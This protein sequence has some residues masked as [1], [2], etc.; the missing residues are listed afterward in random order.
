MQMLLQMCCGRSSY[1][2]GHNTFAD[3]QLIAAA[4]ISMQGCVR[5]EPWHCSFSYRF[6][7][8]CI[9]SAAQ[10]NLHMATSLLPQKQPRMPRSTR[11][12]SSWCYSN[13][14]CRYCC[15]C[16]CVRCSSATRRGGKPL[17][18]L[19]LLAVATEE[20]QHHHRI[21]AGNP[22][23]EVLERLYPWYVLYRHPSSNTSTSTQSSGYCC[24]TCYWCCYFCCAAAA[25]A[26]QCCLLHGCI[27]GDIAHF[28]LIWSNGVLLLLLRYICI[29]LCEPIL[30]TE[31]TAAGSF[32]VAWNLL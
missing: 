27:W 21:I 13:E 23:L 4:A 9:C 18:L 8:Y 5:T 28:L 1:C 11:S 29:E 12:S 25:A 32:R 22:T 3:I 2:C 15:Y 17:E 19:L 14:D 7:C 30:L 31:V 24:C 26:K 20:L 10:W 16:A 6:C